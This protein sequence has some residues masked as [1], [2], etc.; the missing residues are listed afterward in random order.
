MA[1]PN[2]YK[3]IAKERWTKIKQ[4]IDERE[5]P[6]FTIEDIK[7]AT[8]GFTAPRIAQTL[9]QMEGNG[10]LER[11][12]KQEKLKGGTPLVVY[13]RV[14]KLEVRYE[15]MDIGGV[16]AELY[17]VPHPIGHGRQYMMERK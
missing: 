11:A 4:V 3:D 1:V 5:E 12:G 6:R 17:M 15:H 13:Q 8:T 14:K 9:S 16:W 7:A 2:A 10:Y